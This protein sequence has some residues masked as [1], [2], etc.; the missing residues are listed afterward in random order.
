MAGAQ[1]LDRA[2]LGVQADPVRRPGT[3]NSS[4]RI[5]KPDPL[6][7]LAGSPRAGWLP[8]QSQIRTI[9]LDGITYG[10][11][12]HRRT[13]VVGAPLPMPVRK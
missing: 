11:E 2:L 8:K 6:L 10:G 7:R 9:A 3:L 1:F 5:S 12:I 13:D 4:T